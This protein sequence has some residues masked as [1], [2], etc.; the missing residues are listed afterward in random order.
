MTRLANNNFSLE[1][2]KQEI[3]NLLN[4]E[5]NAENNLNQTQ[6]DI[7]EDITKD[8]IDKFNSDNIKTRITLIINIISLAVNMMENNTNDHIIIK[9]LESK[10]Y[11]ITEELKFNL[12]IADS[13]SEW[14]KKLQSLQLDDP[15]KIVDREPQ[16]WREVMQKIRQSNKKSLIKI[17]QTLKNK[18]LTKEA[19]YLDQIINKY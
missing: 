9:Q 2:A 10:L 17:S 18:K 12:D 13:E 1:S 15:D 4:T 3:F 14:N 19:D 11:Q 7:I 5:F 6:K 8:N 16:N